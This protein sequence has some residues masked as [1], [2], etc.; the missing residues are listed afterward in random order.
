MIKIKTI[1]KI[2]GMFAVFAF[3]VSLMPAAVM[4]ASADDNEASDDSSDAAQGEA[5]TANDML[6]F[7]VKVR[8]G[9]VT[10]DPQSV[11][12]TNFKGSATVDNTARVSLENTL[13][14]ENHTA[15]ADKITEETATKVSWNSLIYSDWDGVMLT[16]SAPAS[17]FV[18][19][20]TSL[21]SASGYVSG[22]ASSYQ[23]KKTA[24]E[25]YSN[26]GETS[27]DVG[28][29]REL[30]VKGY[31][32]SKHP[33]YFMKVFWGRI[34][35]SGY[36]EECIPTATV[37]CTTP[38]LN[39]TGSFKIDSGGKLNLV[40]TLR[41]EWPDK[42]TSKSNTEIDWQSA[43]Y[44]G[45]DGIL[46]HLKL[47]ADTL[48]ASDTV[49]I[50]FDKHAAAGFPKSFG[51]VDLYHNG[52]TKY[53][54]DGTNGYGVAFEVWKKPNKSV[55][56]VKGKP[57]VYVIEDG[58][59][60]PIQ[61]PT[62]L[63]SN[64]LS[65]A[66]VEEVDQEEADTYSDGEPLNYADGT[67]VR[68]SDRPEVYVVANGQKKHILDPI[69]FADLGYNWNNVLVVAPKSLGIFSN[70]AP[71]NS[72]S[73][74]PEGALIRVEGTNTVY[75]VEG[76]KKVPISDIQL[77]NARKY[78][79]NKVLVIK[80]KQAKKFDVS[81]QLTYPDG[82][83]IKDNSGKVYVVDHGKKR[84]IRS[85]EDFK[86]GGF[87]ENKIVSVDST[88]SNQLP[89]GDDVVANDVD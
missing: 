66:D 34:D 51:I 21:D 68:E 67:M 50:N 46:V 71:M 47:D 48:D 38:L 22:G 8:W 54:I 45:I 75:V 78:D 28:S 82:S 36:G 40:K 4:T 15:E 57:T 13:K 83:L 53:V 42:I 81:T 69:A 49:T 5:I 79:W 52:I 16:V 23:I 70:A 37:K 61:S 32:V 87:K 27:V 2:I 72:N 29:G 10:G 59:K 43:L 26:D 86:K 62:V 17:S 64:G 89:A 60:M 25:L 58:L 6:H 44:G 88:A 11:A 35:A 31:K 56:K 73:A 1:K 55:I 14:F 65:F 39:A 19:I 41:F 84:W 77:F 74:H 18:T 63:A 33:S 76:G 9:N 20:D 7:Q 85:S 80:D 3:I 24:Q 30:V 12:Q